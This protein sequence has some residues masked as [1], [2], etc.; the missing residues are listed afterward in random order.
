MEK[1]HGLNKGDRVRLITEKEVVEIAV[2]IVDAQTFIIKDWTKN[3]SEVFVYGKKVA[4]FR[5][6]DFDRLTVLSISAIQ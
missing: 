1:A 4:D 2:E 3:T 5:S 6:V